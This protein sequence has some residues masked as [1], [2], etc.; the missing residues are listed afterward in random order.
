MASGRARNLHAV[1]IPYDYDEI[2]P[3]EKE[4]EHS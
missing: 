3:R 1:H 4:E 2:P